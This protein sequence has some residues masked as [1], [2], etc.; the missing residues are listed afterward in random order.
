MENQV[1]VNINN[2]IIGKIRKTVYLKYRKYRV[3]KNR[4]FQEKF[5][6]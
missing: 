5:N 3:V 4:F 1:R 2:Q 6:K